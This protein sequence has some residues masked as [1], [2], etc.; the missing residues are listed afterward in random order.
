MTARK[1]TDNTGIY[2]N[3]H[4]RSGNGFILNLTYDYE[5]ET[6]PIGSLRVD[7]LVQP[8]GHVSLNDL[9]VC[10]TAETLRE[11]TDIMDNLDEYLESET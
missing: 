4:Y 1:K 11:I 3:S 5:G 6:R 8:F 7:N 10:P 9:N 2:V